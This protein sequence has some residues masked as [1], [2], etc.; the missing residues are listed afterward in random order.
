MRLQRIQC[1][2][3]A[4]RDSYMASALVTFF[5]DTSKQRML[6]RI[7]LAMA[8]VV[9]GVVFWQLYPTLMALPQMGTQ[10]LNRMAVSLMLKP[11]NFLPWAILVITG[12]IWP[13]EMRRVWRPYPELKSIFL[14]SSAA[15]LSFIVDLL[16]S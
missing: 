10:T 14:M 16:R 1:D 7:W 13:W 6:A 11:W 15:A 12:I 8:A 3:G 5:T 2:R 4:W 9:C